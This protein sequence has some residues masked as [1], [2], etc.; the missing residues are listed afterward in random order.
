MTCGGKIWK[1]GR[2]KEGKCKKMIKGMRKMECIKVN[3]CK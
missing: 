3:L 2:E 1:K